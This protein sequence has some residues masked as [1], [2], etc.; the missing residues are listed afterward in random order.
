MTFT[1]KVVLITGSSSGIGAV[2]AM[3]FARL[4][5]HVVVTGRD[6]MRTRRVAHQCRCVASRNAEVIEVI[7]DLTKDCDIRRLI[8]TTIE[9]F[10]KLNVLV[11]NANVSGISPID[12]PKSAYIFNHIMQVNIRAPLLLCQLA[13]PHLELTNGSIVNVSSRAATNP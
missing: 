13:V 6:V 3:H 1:G 11:N 2:V 5:A 7:A 8:R 10:G 9:E 4:G 12:D